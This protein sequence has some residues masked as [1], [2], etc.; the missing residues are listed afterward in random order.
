MNR[1]KMTALALM[2]ASIAVPARS[3]TAA[4]AAP[5]AQPAPAAS[6]APGQCSDHAD[7][8]H[9]GM[10]RGG[11]MTPQERQEMKAK[12][13]AMTPEQKKDFFEKK[14]A[15]WMAN[16]PPEK[17][18]EMEAAMA[19]RKKF[20][21]SLTPEQKEL[22]KQMMTAQHGHHGHHGHHGGGHHGQHH[23]QPGGGGS[24]APSPAPAPAPAGQ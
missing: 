19:A 6:P 7:K 12:L 10:W 8:G 17:K 18:A 23:G 20:M 3:E 4:P 22:W 15:E 16:L 21:D 14:K 13:D 11:G 9:H 5:P 24:P 1:I 2:L